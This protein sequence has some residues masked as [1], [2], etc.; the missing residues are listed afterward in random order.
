MAHTLQYRFAASGST[1]FMHN[2]P[3]CG[4]P[5]GSS[6]RGDVFI[7]PGM[8]ILC[9]G[10]AM[11]AAN[12]SFYRLTPDIMLAALEQAGYQPDGR[13]LM[14]NSLENRVIS[15]MLADSSFCVAKFYRPGRWSR[16]TILEEHA[17]LFELAALEI[18]VCSPLVSQGSSLH[19]YQGLLYAVWPQ[20]GGRGL[21]EPDAEC[22][23][24]IGRLLGRMHAAG[25]KS[26]FSH[27]QT[28]S[29]GSFVE[30]PLA[31]LD[32]LIPAHCRTAYRDAA[33]RIAGL[34]RTGS[35]GVPMQRI[36]GDCH[37]GNLLIDGSQIFFLDFDDCLT[38]P[39]VQDL[40]MLL[41]DRG[42]AAAGL[43]AAFLEGY[44]LFAD[45]DPAWF[46]LIEILRGMRF[47]HY[48]AWI[49]RRRD[50]PSFTRAFP[51]F[52]TDAWWERETRD[53]IEQTRTAEE[54][55]SARPPA[56]DELLPDSAYFPDLG[57]H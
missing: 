56:P 24:H 48:A 14:R 28:L 53:L 30:Q 8:S 3:F 25:A 26:G 23:R 4:H 38:G 21:E 43:R 20:T 49:A 35:E 15:V 27:R 5:P 36:H 10:E 57:D 51:D 39:V 55:L 47:V 1:H 54:G 13:F 42:D 32:P 40:W 7:P 50:D 34:Y 17:F 18:P 37:P 2:P 6:N 9:A 16:E 11:H 45:F 19:E 52:G 22:M 41:P 46:R 31:E 44:T 33:L 29:A 12:D